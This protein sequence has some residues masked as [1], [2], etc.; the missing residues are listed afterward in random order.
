MS[1]YS[2]LMNERLKP[3]QVYKPPK[4]TPQQRAEN[5]AAI[6]KHIADAKAKREAK[7][8]GAEPATD[9]NSTEYEGP[10]LGEEAG[11]PGIGTMRSQ[12]MRP[13][14][15]GYVQV[16]KPKPKPKPT[17]TA[18]KPETSNTKYEGPSLAEQAEYIV[19]FIEEGKR[20]KALKAAVKGGAKKVR[21]A[22]RKAGVVGT[23]ALAL[24]A[25]H[26][27][28]SSDSDNPET[29]RSVAARQVRTDPKSSDAEVRSVP[30]RKLRTGTE[31][32]GFS[33]REK[34]AYLAE[35]AVRAESSAEKKT[36]QKREAMVTAEK[37]LRRKQAERKAG[38]TA[39]PETL[40]LPPP[41][42]K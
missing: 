13:V 15:G 12:G 8:A 11:N 29:V 39:H 5:L 20:L 38:Y 17:K 40:K 21:G 34:L 22:A 25:S 41:G 31:Y 2:E 10:S 18:P 7:A 3:E 23:M 6:R 36:R 4:Q 24:G 42:K 14:R 33:L 26:P 16:S 27:G 32:E 37:T 1:V 9:T 30:G 28:P 35:I 19:W